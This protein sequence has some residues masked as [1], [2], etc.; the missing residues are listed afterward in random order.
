MSAGSEFHRCGAAY[1][2]KRLAKIVVHAG[3]VTVVGFT[4]SVT[5]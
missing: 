5:N 3:I 2:K 1:E 4:T